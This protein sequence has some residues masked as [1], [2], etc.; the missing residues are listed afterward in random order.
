MAGQTEMLGNYEIKSNERGIFSVTLSN[1]AY[2]APMAHGMTF[3]KSLTADV[4]TGKIYPLRDLFKPGSAYVRVLSENIRQQIRRR[5][6][7]T[8]GPFGS[9]KPD[10]DYYLADKA[11]VVYFQLYEIVP[12][13]V[14]FPMFPI[15]VSDLES[16]ASEQGPLAIMA[17]NS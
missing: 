1:Y 17:T 13:Y 8:L 9:I 6:I 16:V 15:P 3:V 4:Q 2:T 12:Y 7:P 5:Q 11:L 14:G 10:Q